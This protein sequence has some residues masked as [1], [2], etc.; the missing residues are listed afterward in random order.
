[1]LALTGWWRAS[2]A[3]SP[4]TGTASTWTSGSNNLTEATNPPSAGT[5]VNGFAP[6]TFD[7]SNDK[8]TAG[9]TA[10]TYCTTTSYTWLCMFFVASAPSQADTIGFW[11]DS[12]GNL[13][14]GFDT[15]GVTAMG[16]DTGAKT[17]NKSCSANAW[18]MAMCKLDSGTLYAGADC[19]WG[20]GTTCGAIASLG[21]AMRLGV[22]FASNFFTGSI[23]E[24]LATDIV[25]T[26]NQIAQYYSYLK[27]RYP[28][29]GLP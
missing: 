4:W 16:F 9:G 23:M 3:G 22:S 7:G 11:Q 5:A 27:T 8:L 18:H 28:A 26:D 20:S 13:G 29:A 25:L 21:S 17:T 24:L 6:A 19:V 15:D 14:M 1:M 10:A 12:A 2:Y